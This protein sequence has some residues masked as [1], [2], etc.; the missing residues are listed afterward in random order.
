M[1][2]FE[3]VY[4]A[5]TDSVMEGLSVY[6]ARIR[7]GEALYREHP[8]EADIV[9]GVPDSGTEA[10]MGYARAGNLPFAPGFVKNR[11]IGRS[12]IFPSQQ[13]RDAAVRLKLNPLVRNVRGKRVVMVDDSIVRGTT[14]RRTVAL[15]RAAGA[16]EVHLLV[17]SP[18][19][20][21][22]CHFGTDID[23]AEN[24]IANRMSVEE[25]A[26]FIG[27]DSVGYLSVRGL[28]EACGGCRLGL[29]LGCFDGEYPV[30]PGHHTKFELEAGQIH[31]EGDLS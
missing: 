13:Q 9:C 19:F 30:S 24:L 31:K 16:K 4:F 23:S 5:R 8:I 20:R 25:T 11:Y 22:E 17:S 29:C 27:A 28:R 6:D 26:A 7:M 2:V 1:C 15:L 18:P 14:S 3:Y 21:Y 12:F 10:A